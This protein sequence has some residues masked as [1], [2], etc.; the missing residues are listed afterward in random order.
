MGHSLA[1]KTPSFSLFDTPLGPLGIIW[2]ERGVVGVQL[3]EATSKGTRLR[4][5]ARFP[6]AREDEPPPKVR[7]TI[8][9]IR[10]LLQSKKCD[11]SK[12]P[13]D[14]ERVPPFHRKVYE[15]ARAIGPGIT[16]SYGELALRAGSPGAA[17]AVGQALRHNPFPIIVPCH[18]VLAAGGRIGGFTASGGVNTKARLLALEG[19]Q[20]EAPSRKS[21]GV[22]SVISSELARILG[23]L[24]K[25][26]PEL[27]KLITRI[28]KVPEPPERTASLFEAL[29][30]SI[31]YQ[32]LTGK[33]AGTIFGRVCDLFPNR[34]PTPERLL[35][36]SD[37]TLRAAGLSG[38]KLL[39]LQDLARR[40]VSG[41]LP[42]LAEVERMSDEEVIERLTVVRGI[43]RW[44]VEML[45]I[46]RLGRADVLPLD[47]YG[48]KKGF[49]V[50]FGL[51]ALPSAAELEQRGARWRPHRSLASW[52][53]WRAAELPKATQS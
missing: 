11:L 31:T 8:G 13:L 48:I 9:Q 4:V 46:F 16:L 44:T 20:S 27:G 36:L 19:T 23:R 53:L 25:A 22:K 12:V 38:S 2:N 45:L 50:A 10:A 34:R 49:A 51:A 15:A 21:R 43:G 47:D 14:L 1:M 52:Y 32:Q 18:R 17:R 6:E 39:S 5:L 37:E 7:R 35:R 30:R 42:T 40:T 41:E 29:A 24:R 28:G 3:P 33:A 26:D